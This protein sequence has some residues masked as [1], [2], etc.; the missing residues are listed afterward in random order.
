MQ[1]VADVYRTLYHYTNWQGL[2]GILESQS[3]WATHYKFQNDHSEIDLFIK[4]K[5]PELL[6]P[7]T[8]KKYQEALSCNVEVRENFAKSGR[9]L[10]DVARYDTQVQ[11]DALFENLHGQIYTTSFCGEDE[12]AY[13][14]S[15]GLLSQW[16]GYG[17]DGGFAIVFDTAGIAKLMQEEAQRFSYGYASICDL[18]YSHDT[19]KFEKEL[20]QSIE[21]IISFYSS[22]I[23]NMILPNSSNIEEHDSYTPFLNCISR[24]KHR[25]FSEENEVRL[26]FHVLSKSY[27]KEE[28][29]LKKNILYRDR[30]N[31]KIPYL[32]I[33]RGKQVLPIKKIIVGPH[34][35]KET[36]AAFLKT[37]LISSDIEIIISDI[38]Y[39][40]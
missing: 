27:L 15:H 4:R 26:V 36:R 3:L 30:N 1:D 9:V 35:E 25:G 13:I 31:E 11:I 16:R 5:F 39:V 32:E 14:N 18:I 20:A 40:G 28:T 6:Y 17:K 10:E 19:E 2:I 34:K 8:L 24:Y 21:N 37:K 23:D 33:F 7:R 38:P 12:D 22:V 29:R